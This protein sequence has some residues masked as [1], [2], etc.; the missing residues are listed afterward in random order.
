MNRPRAEVALF[1]LTLGLIL[2][3]CTK[4]GVNGQE[5][6][7]PPTVAKKPSVPFE[8]QWATFTELGFKLNPGIAI[9]DVD[10]WGGK[11]EFEEPPYMVLYMTLG[12][13]IE[14]E[15]WTPLTNRVWD[16]DVEAVEDRGA[17]VEIMK[18]LERISRGEIKFRDLKDYVD[19]EEKKAWV[20]FSI[21]GRNYKWNLA[22]D[23]DWADPAL[24]SKVVGLTRTLKTKGR[25][26]YFNTGGQNAVI[27][28]ETPESREAIIKAT[29]LKIEWLN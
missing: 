13:T 5:L 24:F 27:G 14:R 2:V 29:G 16:F 22:V 7:P 23:D 20:S 17:Y 6:P 9:S 4:N 10:R 28:F 18:N 12:Q 8:K 21:G 26:T 11:T 3:G 1:I 15:P 25:Y 19:I